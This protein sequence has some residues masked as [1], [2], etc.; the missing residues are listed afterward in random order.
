VAKYTT[1][2]KTLI[3]INYDLGLGVTDYPIFDESYRS[4]LNAR[5]LDHFRF[6]EIGFETPGLFKY[7]LNVTMREKMPVLNQYYLNARL[8]FNPLHAVN[9]TETSKREVTG[10]SVSDGTSSSNTESNTDTDN[11]DVRSDTP[12]GLLSLED[13]EDPVN[14]YATQADIGKTA[15]TSTGTGAT[16]A[17]SENTLN[18]VDDYLKTLVGSNGNKS[19]SELI[20][21]HRKTFINVDEMVFQALESCFMQ[22]W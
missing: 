6:R 18:N 11:R 7:W 19:Q 10:S 17:R 9:L 13:M 1:L 5:I 21:E 22:V 3:D 14:K 15:S 2:L 4:V 20:L 16:T 8:E 12:Q